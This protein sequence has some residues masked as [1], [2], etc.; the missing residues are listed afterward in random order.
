LHAFALPSAGIKKDAIP[1]RLNET[2][3]RLD[4]PGTYFGQCSEIC[5]TG[6]AYMPIEVRA[7]TREEFDAWV[8]SKGGTL[9][10]NNSITAMP[11]SAANKQANPKVDVDN[12]AN[13]GI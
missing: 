5:G 11:D 4:T 13:P 6:H 1:G 10:E 2:W 7:V 8:A 9:K 12:I 3:M